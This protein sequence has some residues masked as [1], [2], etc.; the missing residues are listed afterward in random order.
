MAMLNSRGAS[1]VPNRPA[2]PKLRLSGRTQRGVPQRGSAG[3]RRQGR[4]GGAA[5]PLPSLAPS[6]ARRGGAGAG[7]TVPAGRRHS[8]GVN[9]RSMAPRHGQAHAKGTESRAGPAAGGEKPCPFPVSRAATRPRRRLRPPLQATSGGAARVPSAARLPTSPGQDRGSGTGTGM[10]PAPGCARHRDVPG[11]GMRSAP[12]RQGTPLQPLHQGQGGIASHPASFLSPWSSG[13]AQRRRAPQQRAAEERRSLPPH[14]PA[15]VLP[16]IPSVRPSVR[17]P[18]SAARSGRE[19]PQSPARS[20][21]APGWDEAG[22]QGLLEAFG[23]RVSEVHGLDA[24]RGVFQPNN[25]V[26]ACH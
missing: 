18:G 26:I 8:S 14:L 22:G 12:G 6:A 4:A 13:G 16:S 5:A 21:Y 11:T 3:L 10:C 25:Y 24:R 15:P 20:R 1:T 7:G 23:E 19:R 17:R 9:T 2:E